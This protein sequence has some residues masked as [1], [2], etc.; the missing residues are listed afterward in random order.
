MGV[1]VKRAVSKSSASLYANSSWD[2]I[3][4][5]EEED[6]DVG[7]LNRDQLPEEY[8]SKSDKE[9]E[10]MIE[11]KKKERLKIQ[12]EIRDL[13]SKR[14]SY[15]DQKNAEEKGQ[16]ETAMLRAIKKQATKKNYSWSKN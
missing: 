11:T 10:A 2:L 8:R 4:A 16:L 9:I 7:D 13:N 15:I 14:Q 5:A 12:E 3:D 6:F 1:A